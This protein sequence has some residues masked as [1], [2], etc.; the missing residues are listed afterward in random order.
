M[1]ES[2]LSKM[3]TLTEGLIDRNNAASQAW[4]DNEPEEE[5]RQE[6]IIKEWILEKKYQTYSWQSMHEHIT[7]KGGVMPTCEEM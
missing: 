3:D 5:E 6:R 1:L 4:F 7:D 2:K